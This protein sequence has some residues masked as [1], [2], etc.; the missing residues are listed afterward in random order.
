CRRQWIRRH[1]ARALNRSRVRASHLPSIPGQPRGRSDPLIPLRQQEKT[2][3]CVFVPLTLKPRGRLPYRG[4]SLLRIGAPIHSTGNE[5]KAK[6]G[7]PD[8]IEGGGGRVP[9]DTI[10][11]KHSSSEA[12]MRAMILTSPGSPLQEVDLPVPE[13][14]PDQVLIRVHACGVCRTDLH[15]VDG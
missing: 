11:R 4:I 5:S 7:A 3:S 2:N 12:I 13:P 6:L 14:A 9:T 10:T 8:V 1:P 15:V